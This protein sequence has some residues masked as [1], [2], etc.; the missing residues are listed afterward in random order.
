MGIHDVIEGLQIPLQSVEGGQGDSEGE[1]PTDTQG[2]DRADHRMLLMRSQEHQP[3][4]HADQRNR[5]RHTEI[6]AA[7]PDQPV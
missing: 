5:G 1:E 7:A 3:Y 6:Q 2:Y 4:R